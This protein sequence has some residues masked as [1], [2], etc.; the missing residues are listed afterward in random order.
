MCLGGYMENWFGK[1]NQFPE[2]NLVRAEERLTQRGF[3]VRFVAQTLVP[4]R[5]WKNNQGSE[6]DLMVIPTTFSSITI[7]FWLTV[8]EAT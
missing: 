8:C 4:A 6:D 1:V 3:L 7:M 5:L 2:I